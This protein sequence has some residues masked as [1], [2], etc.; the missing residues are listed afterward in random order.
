M[1]QQ[2]ARVQ[3]EWGRHSMRVEDERSGGASAVLK[4]ERNAEGKAS[5]APLTM[6]IVG[7]YRIEGGKIAEARFFWDF[8]EALGAVGVRDSRGPLAAGGSPSPHFASA[9]AKCR[10]GSGDPSPMI[11]GPG[12]REKESGPAKIRRSFRHETTREQARSP[13]VPRHRSSTCRA[14]GVPA[15]A[16]PKLPAAKKGPEVRYSCS[17]AAPRAVS[18]SQKDCSRTILPSRTVKMLPHG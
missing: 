18:R 15:A 12:D 6:K 14:V 17:P 11:G 16:T 8:D 3:E 10:R 7:A 4:L 9:H 2:F 5:G 1:I 13:L